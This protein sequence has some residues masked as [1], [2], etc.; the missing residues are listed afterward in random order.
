MSPLMVICLLVG[1]LILHYDGVS[2]DIKGKY[3]N[4][5]APQEFISEIFDE[6][7]ITWDEN[8]T[9][10]MV[11]L[12]NSNLHDPETSSDFLGS[13]VSLTSVESLAMVVDDE[14]FVVEGN[15]LSLNPNVI[16]VNVGLGKLDFSIEIP[17]GSVYVY[18]EGMYA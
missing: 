17:D 1:R 5:T 13:V 11:D 4:T 9:L 7:G 2:P 8:F 18:P 10:V 15:I 6:S 16:F 14:R 3:S 12:L